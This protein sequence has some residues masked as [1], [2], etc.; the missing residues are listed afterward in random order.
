MSDEGKFL[1][2]VSRPL[3][4]VSC[5]SKCELLPVNIAGGF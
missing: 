3:S 2:P 4:L 5:P 1:I